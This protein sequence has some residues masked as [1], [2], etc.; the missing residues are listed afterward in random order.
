MCETQ[1]REVVG[2]RGFGWVGLHIKGV[3]TGTVLLICRYQ[4]SLGEVVSPQ[5]AKHQKMSKHLKI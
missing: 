5:P 1:L 4:L 3:L 2:G